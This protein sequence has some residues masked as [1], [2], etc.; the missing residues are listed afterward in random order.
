MLEI[1]ASVGATAVDLTLTSSAGEKKWF[2]RNLALA[3]FGRMLGNAG[4]RHGKKAQCH[5][6]AQYQSD[7]SAPPGVAKIKKNAPSESL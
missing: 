4:R 7:R 5:H 1:C 6:K 3:E 2:R